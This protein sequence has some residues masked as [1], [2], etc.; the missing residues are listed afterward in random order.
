MAGILAIVGP[1]ASGKSRIAIEIAKK[2]NGAIINGDPFQAF[3]G[4]PIGTGQP[5]LEEQQEVPH[6]GYGILPLSST[7]N[8]AS[9]GEMAR[10]WAGLAHKAKKTP[11]LVTGSG[12]YL[13]GIWDHLDNLPPVQGTTVAK[14]RNLCQQ[15]GPPAL[16]RY[17]AAVDK[18]RASQLHPNDGSRIQRALSLHLATGKRP[19]EL[20]TG[21]SRSVP[22]G[23]HAILIQPQREALKQRIASRVKKMFSD[24]WPAEAQKLA[25]DGYESCIRR[26]R[27]LGYELLLDA[28]NLET[29]EQL[30]IQATQ[31]YAKRQETWF[32]NQ[33]PEAQRFDPVR[34][35]ICEIMKR[36]ISKCSQ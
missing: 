10:G 28:P 24:G 21:V 25:Q 27:P 35:D 31:A 36:C 13:R 5:T 26:L 22:S 12:L 1:T 15:L 8:P 30:I 17:L 20:L 34:D 11:I 29:A 18:E 16:H 19:S 23:W 33:L 9:F 14:L 7:I 6:F 32:K 4:I 3:Q 2:T